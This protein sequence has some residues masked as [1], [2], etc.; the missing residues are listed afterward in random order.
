MTTWPPLFPTKPQ[1]HGLL[2]R[3]D[4]IKAKNDI[5]Q[6]IDGR[7]RGMLAVRSAAVMLVALLLTDLAS[8][9]RWTDESSETPC[10][11]RLKVNH[12]LC[13]CLDCWIPTRHFHPFIINLYISDLVTLGLLVWKP[14]NLASLMTVVWCFM[15]IPPQHFPVNT[16]ITAIY[17]PRKAWREAET[18]KCQCRISTTHLRAWIDFFLANFSPFSIDPSSPWLLKHISA[19]LSVFLH[20]LVKLIS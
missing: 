7:K 1:H 16:N 19:D 10:Q 13:Y 2:G 11:K 9:G 20:F 12:S 15:C 3:A 14:A 18:M 17:H 5:N 4:Q 6:S 8:A